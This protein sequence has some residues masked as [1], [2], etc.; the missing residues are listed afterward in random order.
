VPGLGL[1][2]KLTLDIVFAAACHC[3]STCHKH[4]SCTH[5]VLMLPNSV[6]LLR[7][8]VGAWMLVCAHGS[9]PHHHHSNV[10]KQRHAIIDLL[11][12]SMTLLP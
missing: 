7:Q 5:V 8:V 6:L 1:H 2:A 11:L 4:H 9:C 3:M 12:P 10:Q